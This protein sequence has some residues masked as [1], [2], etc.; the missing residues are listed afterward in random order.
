MGSYDKG[1]VRQGLWRADACQNLLGRG[2]RTKQPATWASVIKPQ[3]LTLDSEGSGELPASAT[4]C[5]SW[6]EGLCSGLH[7]TPLN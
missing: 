1:I 2:Y 3:E 7:W 4:L 6:S 5:V